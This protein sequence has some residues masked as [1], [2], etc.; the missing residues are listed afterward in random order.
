MIIWVIK[1]KI[2]NLVLGRLRTN[3]YIVKKNNKCIII[4]PGDEAEKIIEACKG[5]EVEEILV[6][7]H[8]WDHILAL[9]EIEEQYHLKHNVFLK[10][11][12]SYEIIKT[13]GHASDSLTFYFKDEKVMF[14]EDFLFFHTIGRCDL[15]TSSIEDMK[16][17]LEE[18]KKYPDDIKIYPGHGRGSV[19]GE[20]KV[21]FNRYF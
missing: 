18:I 9:K 11:S 8:H 20:E 19:L 17:S 13:P 6:T 2:E 12:F 7:H 5:Y 16:K 14:T 15:E 3:C 10:K 1:L 4:D 21:L